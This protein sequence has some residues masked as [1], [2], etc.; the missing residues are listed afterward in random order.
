MICSLAPPPDTT[1][2]C[3]GGRGATPPQYSGGPTGYRLMLKRQ[4]MGEKMFPPAEVETVIRM[5]TAAHPAG[6]ASTCE[7]LR[8]VIAKSGV[9]LDRRLEESGPLTPERF[10]LLEAN[11]RLAKLL[12]YRTFA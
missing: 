1:P 8:D 4:E 6:P 3:V 5:L 11:E 2:V 9:S 12:Q 10:S 7:V